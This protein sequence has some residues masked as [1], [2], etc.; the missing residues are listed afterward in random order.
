M[1]RTITAN[2]LREAALTQRMP[3]IVL[4]RTAAM[5]P[6]LTVSL[7][8]TY[9]LAARWLAARGMSPA[10][11]LMAR[12][13]VL[14][15]VA[16]QSPFTWSRNPRQSISEAQEHFAGTNI[17]PSWFSTGNTGMIGLVWG[18]VD[19]FFRKQRRTEMSWT[20][21]DI[22]QN[23]LMGLK[24]DG[25]H[26]SKGPLFYQVGAYNPGIKK[27]VPG[28]KDTP[29]SV[30]A[31]AKAFFVQKAHNQLKELEK[32]RQTM[33]TE[34]GG[35]QDIT[36]D[37]T[38]GRTRLRIFIDII[39][40]K[41][42]PLGQKLRGLIRSEWV[43]R[44]AAPPLDA[45][46]DAI[47]AGQR[48]NQS[49][50]AKQFGIAGS[51]LQRNL[52]A[53]MGKAIS[54]INANKTLQN[55]ISEY[56]D[57]EQMRVAHLVNR[58]IGKMAGLAGDAAGAARALGGIHNSSTP[59]TI[60][61]AIANSLV[62]I[63]DLANAS[64]ERGLAKELYRLSKLFRSVEAR[65]AMSGRDAAYVASLNKARQ[66]LSQAGSEMKSTSFTTTQMVKDSSQAQR[67]ISEAGGLVLHAHDVAVRLA[68]TNGS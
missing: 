3:I 42:D 15:G 25:T 61:M 55:E 7:R 49:D 10:E 33:V 58:I 12:L 45:W 37:M 56:I 34:E 50:I 57:R 19:S 28:G 2:T 63:S 59:D 66:R 67:W 44:D 65:Q 24:L 13:Q 51:T 41:R 64:K 43:G 29:R 11:D 36:W 21:D 27:N 20:A 32:A 62:W 8:R 9:R 46:M 18:S 39:T 52:K 5:N 68:R 53:Y 40:D 35:Q 16:G 31:T 17:D 30:G 47:E 14:E 60:N 22:L 54:K 1:S 38:S 4:L 26:Y 6:K 23:G 48:A